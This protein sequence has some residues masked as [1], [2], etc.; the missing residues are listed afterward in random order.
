MSSDIVRSI[1]S[2]EYTPRAE[3][4]L[5]HAAEEAHNAGHRVIGT[6]HLLLGLLRSGNSVGA[7]ILKNLGVPIAPATVAEIR[8]MLRGG[9][10]S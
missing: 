6:E 7:T 2:I 8:Y 4:V 1:E 5:E 3:K 9:P 10:T